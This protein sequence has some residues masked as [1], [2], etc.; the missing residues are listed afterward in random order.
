MEKQSFAASKLC[1]WAVNIVKFNTIFK[2]VDPLEKS[3]DEA[4]ALLE[5]K[6][7][8]LATVK[9][10]VRILNEKVGALKK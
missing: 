1:A 3:R 2:I 5:L 10:K 6:K 7:K 9:E 4:L 8:E